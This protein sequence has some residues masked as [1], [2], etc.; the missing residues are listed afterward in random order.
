[1]DEERETL[2]KIMKLPS[3]SGISMHAE[4]ITVTDVV[5]DDCAFAESGIVKQSEVLSIACNVDTNISSNQGDTLTLQNE[6]AR[7]NS[8]QILK[9]PKKMRKRRH[10]KG[11]VLT[12]VGLPKKCVCW[13]YAWIVV[14]LHVDTRAMTTD[15]LIEESE[16]EVHLEKVPIKC[17]DENVCINNIR[18]FFTYDAWSLVHHVIG[19]LQA[20]VAWTGTI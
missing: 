6:V 20:K 7:E 15:S 16:V 2:C 4:T 5:L 17:L 19:T 11:A 9:L 13:D 18:M 3:S 12:V 14:Q 8:L 10:P 1:M